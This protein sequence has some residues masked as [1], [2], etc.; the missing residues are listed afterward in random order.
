MACR[1]RERALLSRGDAGR[2]L[3]RALVGVVRIAAVQHNTTNQPT[4]QPTNRYMSV[5]RC[6]QPHALSTP[7]LLAA[8]Y[9]PTHTHS[10]THTRT[11]PTPSTPPGGPMLEHLSPRDLPLIP[12][13]RGVLVSGLPPRARTHDLVA[14]LHQARARARVWCGRCVSLPDASDGVSDS[15]FVH[16]RSCVCAR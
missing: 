11:P 16:A 4:N 2:A 15:C 14:A 7:V 6:S 3:T 10:H 9:V 1:K 8:I 13:L 5:D 12:A